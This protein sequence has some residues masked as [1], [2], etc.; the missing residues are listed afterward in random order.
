L[1][2]VDDDIDLEPD[3]LLL[4]DFGNG[5]NRRT[6]RAST[7]RTLE[8][9]HS[10]PLPFFG[11]GFFFAKGGFAGGGGL[12]EGF[13]TTL[14]LYRSFRPLARRPSRLGLKMGAASQFVVSPAGAP[15]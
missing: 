5:G 14:R 2:L 11:S 1:Q 3:R 12:K 4:S 15:C 8:L 7:L 13:T 6:S 9:L 10:V